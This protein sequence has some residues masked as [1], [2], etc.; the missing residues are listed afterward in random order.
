MGTKDNIYQ[1]IMIQRFPF[2]LQLAVSCLGGIVNF[3]Q[4]VRYFNMPDIVVHILYSWE[5][6]V[7]SVS[8]MLV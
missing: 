8:S 6:Q 3:L 4:L 2:M 5:R 1:D 7:I